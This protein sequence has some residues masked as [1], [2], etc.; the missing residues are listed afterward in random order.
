MWQKGSRENRKESHKDGR[1]TLIGLTTTSGSPVMCI[2]IFSAEELSFEQ[3][4]GHDITVP[5]DE[6]KNVRDNSGPGK[7][8]PV[9]R[10]FMFRGVSV[11]SLVTCSPK[12]CITSDILAAVF[13]RLDDLQIYH[14]T[15]ALKPFDAH[16]YPIQLRSG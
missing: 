14:L 15:P 12:G 13:K 6:T 7:R 8:F 5:F 10:P 2:C 4:M 3:R 9:G 1:F 11:P 16:K